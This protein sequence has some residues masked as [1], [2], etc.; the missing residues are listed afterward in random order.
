MLQKHLLLNHTIVCNVNIVIIII[1]IILATG[2]THNLFVDI[3]ISSHL[4]LNAAHY[5]G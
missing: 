1:I 3:C 2:G 5:P 4:L